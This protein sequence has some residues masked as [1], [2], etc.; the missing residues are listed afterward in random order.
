[1]Y[2]LIAALIA[3]LLLTGCF[4]SP[5]KFQ[6]QLQLMQDGSFG[7]SYTGEIQFVALSK[8]AEMGARSEEFAPE[9]CYTD[10]FEERACTP[11][12]IAEQKRAWQTDAAD[13]IANKESEAEQL[14]LMMGGIDPSDPE[15]AAEFSAKLQR[16]RG[17]KSVINK[18]DGVFEVDFAINGNLTHD[19]LFPNIEGLPMGSSF[20]N[21][22]LREENKVRIEAPG[23]AAQGAGNPMQGMMGGMMGMANLGAKDGKSELPNLVM[24][25]GRFTI[26]TDGS[27]LANNTDEGPQAAASG[28]ML[29]WDINSQTQNAPAA[30]IQL[31]S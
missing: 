14:K 4:L 6:S 10:D 9:D 12:E 21:I 31:G 30:L 3:P 15:A 16:Q 25:E 29:S 7:Y 11:E 19:F 1:M 18:G 26:V 22:Y 5:G 24:A 20:V 2:R 23:F 13:R 8:L 27:I 28:Q 17:W